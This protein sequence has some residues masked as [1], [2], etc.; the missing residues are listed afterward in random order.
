[1]MAELI[2]LY[3]LVKKVRPDV[4][5]AHWIIPQGIVA[6]IVSIITK[7]PYVLTTMGGDIYGLS[8][9]FFTWLKQIAINNAKTL[10][11]L[12]NDMVREI[13]E[14]LNINKIPLVIPLGVDTKQFN[15][16]KYD[17][18]IKEKY[19][20]DGHFL[21]FVGRLAEKK[22]VT[23]LI[24]AMRNVVDQFSDTKLL[25]IG[26]GPL[27]NELKKQV[28]KLNLAENVLF[29]GAIQNNHLPSYFATADIF[30]GPSIQVKGGDTEGLGVTFI[31]AISSGCVT[32][33]TNVG[34]IGD[35]I[36]NGI[37]GHIVREKSPKGL[38]DVIIKSI[39]NQS[40]NKILVKNGIC[41]AEKSFDWESVTSRYVEMIHES[42][43]ECNV[44]YN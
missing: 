6:A 2:A 3:R 24:D 21:L 40:E 34:G 18:T 31:E 19:G 37:N 26:N 25:I 10:T 12:S 33:G 29:V 23:Y 16:D 17:H 14:R 13:K 41:I 32:V 43:Q 44:V 27:E 9:A 20:I 39:T 30:I 8:G 11:V 5:H 4:I 15:P 7:V 22:G 38:S 1:M 36:K 35:I 42:L 28:S